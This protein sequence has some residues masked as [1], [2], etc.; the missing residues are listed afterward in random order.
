M[1]L[2]SLIVAG[3]VS[4]CHLLTCLGTQSSILL[5]SSSPAMWST[6]GECALQLYTSIDPVHLESATAFD[7]RQLCL[8]SVPSDG[9]EQDQMVSMLDGK[10]FDWKRDYSDTVSEERD[11]IRWGFCNPARNFALEACAN[12]GEIT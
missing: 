6:R 8:Q 5:Y 2:S 3:G 12:S 11:R 9:Q 10:E 4:Q 1:D 7:L